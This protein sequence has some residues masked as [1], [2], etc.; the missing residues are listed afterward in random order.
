ML[1]SKENEKEEWLCAAF[2]ETV[3][4]QI[5]SADSTQNPQSW[6]C[7]SH[8]EFQ[9]SGISSDPQPGLQNDTLLKRT[10]QGAKKTAQWIKCSPYLCENQRQGLHRIP[11]NTKKAWQPTCNPTVLGKQIQSN[12]GA[13][14]L[15]TLAK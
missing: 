5:H 15:A 9:P 2:P 10:K 13:S 1:K 11:L 7:G 14:W 4:K 6:A 12:P 3:W 8:L